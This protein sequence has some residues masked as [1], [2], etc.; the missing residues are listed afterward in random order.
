MVSVSYTHLDVYKRQVRISSSQEL[1]EAIHNQKD[2][3]TW[4]LEA[5]LYDLGGDCLDVVANI[6]GVEKGFVFPLFVDDLSIRGEGEVS[7]TS[8]YDPATGNWAGQNFVTVG[9]NSVTL[10][11]SLIHI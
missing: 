2:G 10:E 6:N 8:S 9:G 5:G 11:L 3:Q 4:V 1:V 7:I